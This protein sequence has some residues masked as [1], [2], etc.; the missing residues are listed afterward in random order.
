MWLSM[1]LVGP[2]YKRVDVDRVMG[3]TRWKALFRDWWLTAG[4]IHE[5][6]KGQNKQP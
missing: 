3:E 4:V 6:S 5:S 1:L 2:R